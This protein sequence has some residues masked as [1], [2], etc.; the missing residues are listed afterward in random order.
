MIKLR[1]DFE[2]AM[3]RQVLSRPRLRVTL[4]SALGASLL[5]FAGCAQR[6]IT[7]TTAL[8]GQLPSA[9]VDM[10]QVQ[11]AYIGSGSTGSGVLHRQGRDYPFN[12]SGLG[13]GG[14][15][16]STI[17]AQ[18]AVY[19]LSSPVQF[20][21]AYGQGRYGFAVGSSSGGDLWLKNESGVVMHLLAKRTGLML[22]LGGDAMVV[23]MKN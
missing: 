8:S 1:K 16:A 11:V 2:G 21:G 13:I 10:E 20:A 9:T 18:G 22:S 3:V 17:Q 15:G 6:P 4:F 12:I 7:D 19:N 5:A 14:I 23:T